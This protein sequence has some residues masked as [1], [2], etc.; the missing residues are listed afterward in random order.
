M[1]FPASTPPADPAQPTTK[2]TE[3]NLDGNGS[4]DPNGSHARLPAGRRKKSGG[5]VWLMVGAGGALV[6]VIALL[7]YFFRFT[8]APFNDPTFNRRM[9]QASLLTGD[10]RYSAY[11]SLDVAIMQQAVPW[12]PRSNANNRMLVSKRLGCFTYS[13]IYTVDLAAACLK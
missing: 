10:A 8:T 5:T 6:L 12:A 7:L 9:T 4:V 13:P 3:R 2:Q 1:T 11:G